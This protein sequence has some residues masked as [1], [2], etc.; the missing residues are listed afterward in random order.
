MIRNL[1]ALGLAMAAAFAFSAIAASGASAQQGVLT[2]DGPVTL[3]ATENK[4]GL[5]AL[6]SFEGKT[7]CP[8]S[9]YTGHKFDV[10]PHELIPNQAT[11]A[12]LTPHYKQADCISEDAGGTVRSSTVHMNGCDYV[13][14][15]GETTGGEHTYGVTA[16]VVCPKDKHIQ[17]TVHT[18]QE[19]G[20][21]TRVCT[22]TV[23]PQTGL[24]GA[25]VTTDTANHDLDIKG[26]FTDIAVT[27]SGLCGHAEEAKG[28]FHIDATVTGHNA[29]GKATGI[30]VTH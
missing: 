22:V 28:E 13:F 10:T 29:E 5:N 18:D 24:K 21:F 9:T 8:G 26:T 3:T 1:K 11:T 30:T 4:E 7:E 15:L 17:V 14:H 12:T 27:K 20:P 23:G 2:S 19:H 6:T 16:D 25:H